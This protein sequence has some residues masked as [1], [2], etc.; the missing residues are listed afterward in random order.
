MSIRDAMNDIAA[1]RPGVYDIPEDDYHGDAA[2]A[3]SLSAGCAKTLLT[4]SPWHAAA[5]HPRLAAML[6]D[7]PPRIGDEDEPSRFDVGRAAH[8]II[9]GVGGE[10][11]RVEANDWRS[12]AA[13]EARDEARAAGMT[14]LLSEQADRVE[15][16]VEAA[17]AQLVA[18]VGY[19]PFGKREQNEQSMFWRDG[20]VWCRAR[21]DAIDYEHRILWDLKTTGML[22]DPQAWTDTQVR[23]TGIDLRAAHYLHGAKHLIGP[24]WRYVFA[25]VEARWPHALS[26]V[27]LPGSMLDTGEDM[28]KRAVGLFGRCLASGNWPAWPM[29]IGGI[30]RV[31]ER[32]YHEAR[33][34][35]TRDTKISQFALDASRRAQAPYGVS[36][37]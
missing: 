30:V 15:V 1:G 23:A 9:T 32:P 34:V 4:A 25:V 24:G 16:L 5:E 11:A 35:E 29:G 10:I 7:L 18:R 8:A 26:A 37:R 14:P 22:A 31:E 28:R 36:V 17:V 20:D 12:K 27:E 19:N 2:P 13:K 21:P 3:P 6:D 33:W